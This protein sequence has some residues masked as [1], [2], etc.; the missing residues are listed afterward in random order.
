MAAARGGRKEEGDDEVEWA[1]HGSDSKEK[2]REQVA[3]GPFDLDRTVHNDENVWTAPI[4]K[5][6]LTVQFRSDGPH[7]LERSDRPNEVLIGPSNLDRTVHNDWNVRATPNINQDRLFVTDPTVDLNRGSSDLSSSAEV[8]C[9]A[10]NTVRYDQ[11]FNHGITTWR[12]YRRYQGGTTA[13]VV[14]WVVTAGSPPSTLKMPRTR[15]ATRK[16]HGP[17]RGGQS[18]SQP[19]PAPTQRSRSVQ[20]KVVHG[21]GKRPAADDPESEESE[22]SSSHALSDSESET[23]TEPEVQVHVSPDLTSMK[24]VTVTRYVESTKE[25][26]ER[27]LRTS[28]STW[29][30]LFDSPSLL[31]P[32]WTDFYDPA[33]RST[34]GKI[35]G[36]KPIP[37]MINR[38]INHTF[39]PKSGN[40]D[41]VRGYA[42]NI[43]DN[44]MCGRR[45][46]IVDVILRGIVSSKNDRVKMIYYAPYIMVL[47]LKKI[48]YQ[49]GLGSPHKTYKPRDG[50]PVHHDDS[51]T[52]V[53][54]AQ[55]SAPAEGVSTS[56]TLVVPSVAP[57]TASLAPALQDPA[58]QDLAPVLPQD[59]TSAPPAP[60][61]ASP[62]S[63]S[64]P[65]PQ[66]PAPLPPQDPAV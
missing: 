25:D 15:I 5:Q 19:P 4:G 38:I 50:P 28:S 44:I 8:A 20:Q 45:F 43:I 49:G 48:E 51:S 37:S 41:A 63:T 42:W 47:I 18:S 65:A 17:P 29:E 39:Y 40:F 53:A 27:V 23:E 14:I 31:P 13:S 10:T 22:E 61:P 1:P 7:W 30:K 16:S 35:H 3:F 60:A 55:E 64:V 26:F 36:L 46:D 6:D 59:P 32:A 62:P 12:Y 11:H 66:D 9:G 21:K 34:P 52:A 33:V 24:W 56:S 58:P 2:K 54:A 57:A